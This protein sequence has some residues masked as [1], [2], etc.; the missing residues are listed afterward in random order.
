[1]M[2]EEVEFKGVYPAVI[3]PFK[4]DQEVDEKRLRDFLDHVIEGGVHGIY[5]L[6][7]NGEAP[8]LSLEEKKR[9][10]GIALD[11]V[12]DRVPVI[13]GT[14]CNSTVKTAELA[15]YAEEKG[16]DAV[17]VI[18]PYYYPTNPHLLEKHLK[19]VSKKTDLPIFLYS[20]PQFTGNEIKPSTVSKLAEIEQLVGVKDSSGDVEW[21]YETVKEVQKERQDFYFFG[22]NDSL[23]FT[24]LMTGGSGSVT[25]V[26]NV[27]PELIVKIYENYSSGN[28]EKAKRAQAKVM[29]IKD[30][31]SEFP[32]ISAVKGGLK[33]RGKDFG[34]PRGPLHSLDDSELSKL[35]KKLKSIDVI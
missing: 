25:A 17:H 35:K 6:G 32:P 1:M 28:F 20:I 15:G 30:I 29:K 13:A 9:V 22:G 33:I 7:T 14:M 31:F 21:F 19:D 11:H 2:N 16:A 18:V 23:V 10:M 4:K 5:L 27:F 12:D 8:L 34:E 3:T 26:G 24:Y